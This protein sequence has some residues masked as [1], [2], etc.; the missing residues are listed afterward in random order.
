MKSDTEDDELEEVLISTIDEE[1]DIEA[2]R[3]SRKTEAQSLLR[4]R[5]EKPA[6]SKSKSGISKHVTLSNAES[7]RDKVS[8]AVSRISGTGERSSKPSEPFRSTSKDESRRASEKGGASGTYQALTSIP[9]SFTQAIPPPRA[10]ETKEMSFQEALLA[11]PPLTKGSRTHA[12]APE[13]A[14][15]WASHHRAVGSS[16]GDR[17]P[18]KL[19]AVRPSLKKIP[20]NLKITNGG[21]IHIMPTESIPEAEELDS[22][23]IPE[24]DQPTKLALLGRTPSKVVSRIP[25]KPGHTAGTSSP[26]RDA[27]KERKKTADHDADANSNEDHMDAMSE[28]GMD[29]EEKPKARWKTWR[30]WKKALP[31]LFSLLMFIAGMLLLVIGNHVKIISFELWR[32]FLF[33]AGITPICYVSSWFIHYTINMLERYF[34]AT[35]KVLYFVVGMKTGVERLLRA[36][37]IM[38]LFAGLFRAP[39]NKDKGLGSAYITIIRVGA[40]IILFAGASVLKTL[41]AKIMSSHFHQEAHFKKMQDAVRKEYFLVALSQPRADKDELFVAPSDESKTSNRSATDM[42]M[43]GHK[44][45]AIA[46]KSPDVEG[47][48]AFVH[49]TS[50]RER[51]LNRQGGKKRFGK[52]NRHGYQALDGGDG[53]A[54]MAPAPLTS[55]QFE[56][57]Q[58]S[59]SISNHQALGRHKPPSRPLVAPSG[60]SISNAQALGRELYPLAVVKPSGCAVV[61]NLEEL[62]TRTRHEEKVANLDAELFPGFIRSSSLKK[63]QQRKSANGRSQSVATSRGLSHISQLTGSLGSLASNL[64]E[65]EK[66]SRFIPAKKKTKELK[67]HEQLLLHKLPTRPSA[68]MDFLDKLHKVEQH[69]R[70]NKLKLT[71]TDQLGRAAGTSDEVASKNEAKKLAFYLFW[72][73]KPFFHRNFILQ[74]DIEHFLPPD[75]AKLCFD[76]LDMDGDGKVSLHDMREAVL[77][78][79]QNR[80]HLALTLKDT[81]TIVGK[82][83][84]LV[85]S[86]IHF[87]WIFIYLSIWNVNLTKIW[88]T[89]SS[90]LLSMTFIFGNSIKNTYESVIFLFVVHPFDV[91]DGVYIGTGQTDFYTI[92]E[93]ALL[94]TTLTRYDGAKVVYP[95]PKMNADMVVNLNRSGNRNESIKIL[96][97][98][99]TPLAVFDAIEKDMQE[100]V[101]TN[102]DFSGALAVAASN[103]ADPMKYTLVVW[104]E[105]SFNAADRG[106]YGNA[107]SQILKAIFVALHKAELHYTLPRV[108]E[109]SRE[110]RL[111]GPRG[112]GNRAWDNTP[113]QDTGLTGPTAQTMLAAQQAHEALQARDSQNLLQNPLAMQQLAD[114]NLTLLG[115]TI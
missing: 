22:A 82:L 73:V 35:R 11:L 3:A 13:T 10:K 69:I 111:G 100:W 31:I 75:A 87:V 14:A 2:P 94:N 71:F 39:A 103:T 86:I 101:K 21:D 107:R 4:G 40:C 6:L 59:K 46:S 67:E 76:S 29:D 8:Q 26:N 68:D 41:L 113:Q 78:I 32:W 45:S 17:S 110:E 104:W 23:D 102:A 91:G 105:F 115:A 37:L 96:V 88:Y 19:Q 54:K 109:A 97:D 12:I 36:G 80:K 114:A 64:S 65:K 20:S 33:L 63:Q 70:K 48:R 79:Y 44:Q 93:I 112:A 51:A 106:R 90:L 42:A 95:N 43:G 85:G 99:A 28:A 98:M 77:K 61:T 89:F 16:A 24:F 5:P 1:S 49:S 84:R 62:P 25:A 60:H 83:E 9:N 58:S 38:A 50:L 92:E 108:A 18:T 47:V 30:F 55:S 27:T 52:V 7:F 15:E 74:E 53:G 56:V 72:N 81:R 66:K 34:L 57:E